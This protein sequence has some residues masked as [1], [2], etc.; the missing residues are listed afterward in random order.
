[1]KE[2]NIFIKAIEEKYEKF[3]DYYTMM[4]SDFLSIEEQSAL[5]GFMRR[6][7]K[8]G[9]YFYSGY[10]EAERRM[11]VFLPDYTEAAEKIASMPKDLEER[12]KS[13]EI[14]RILTEYFEENEDSCPISVLEISVPL[15]NTRF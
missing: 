9:V 6:H 2:N 7:S 11:V 14:S 10:G 13:S 8:E 12:E 3:S 5:S 1:M 15:R 4:N